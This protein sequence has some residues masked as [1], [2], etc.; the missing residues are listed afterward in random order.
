MF[1][2]LKRKG[3]QD[4]NVDFWIATLELDEAAMKAA[5]DAGADVNATVGDVLAT[6]EQELSD[7][8]PDDW[9]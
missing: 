3:V 8:N 9:R 1:Q 5:L 4:P 6:H 7:F 2:H